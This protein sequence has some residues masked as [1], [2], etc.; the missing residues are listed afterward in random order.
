M[1]LNKLNKLKLQIKNLK[2]N[3]NMHISKIKNLEVLITPILEYEKNGMIESTKMTPK[4]KKKFKEKISRIKKLLKK[5]FI[6]KISNISYNEKKNILSL[7][8]KPKPKDF[9]I[10]TH[11]NYNKNLQ[12]ITTKF[13]KKY[14]EKEMINLY[15]TFFN[16]ILEYGP[17]TWMEGDIVVIKKNEL[18]NNEYLFNFTFNEIK[19]N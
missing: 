9:D 19:Y 7:T 4:K 15:T 11:N 12:L 5:I 2:E 8:F 16:D 14:T 10:I 1:I 18:D 6:L 13:K 3:F 17:D